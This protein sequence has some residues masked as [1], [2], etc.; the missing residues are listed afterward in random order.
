MKPFLFLT[1]S[2]FGLPIAV[3]AQAF[4]QYPAIAPLQAGSVTCYAQ[5][6]TGNTVDL[7]RICGL[8]TVVTP[9]D[10][11]LLSP[12]TAATPALVPAIAPVSNPF[13]NNSL[14]NSSSNGNSNSTANRCY[15]V[16]SDGSPCSR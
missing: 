16:D 14:G 13:P 2:L 12:G 1:I 10:S 4:E 5:T 6:T 3:R 11:G 9:V 7:S 15:I 8:R